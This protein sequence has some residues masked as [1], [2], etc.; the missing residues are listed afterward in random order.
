MKEMSPS[1]L[2]LL[3]PDQVWVCCYQKVPAWSYFLK[4]TFPGP[5]Q[6][7]PYT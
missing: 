1:D 6:P 2:V 5:T 3:W 4:A 7:I